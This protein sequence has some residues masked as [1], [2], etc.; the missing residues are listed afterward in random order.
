MSTSTSTHQE[1]PHQI[2]GVKSN[3][4]FLIKCLIF[5]LGEKKNLLELFK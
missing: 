3:F 2:K 4:F 1:L 5:I